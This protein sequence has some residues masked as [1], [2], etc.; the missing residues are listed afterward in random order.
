MDGVSA[1]FPRSFL[2]FDVPKYLAALAGGHEA[3]RG[4][5]EARTRFLERRG[6][7]E[8]ARELSCWRRGTAFYLP[9]GPGW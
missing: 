4:R 6:C 5:A 2:A 8:S 7:L 1:D 3:E 9:G